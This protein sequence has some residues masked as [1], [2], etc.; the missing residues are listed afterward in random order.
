M[1]RDEVAWTRWV[2]FVD[3]GVAPDEPGLYRFRRPQQAAP[4]Y[5]GETGNG[6]VTLAK[7]LD[8]L[9]SINAPLMPYRYP[10]AAA[11]ALWSLHDAEGDLE[12]SWATV[13]GHHDRRHAAWAAELA[14]HRHQYGSSP[15]ANFGRMPAGYRSS[16]S[17]SC[18]LIHSGG[19]FRGGRSTRRDAQHQP[20]RAPV[21][22]VHD[23]ALLSDRWCGVEWSEWT[24]ELPPERASG[25]VRVRRIAGCNTLLSIAQGGLRQ[26][27]RKAAKVA[28][29]RV[30]SSWLIIDDWPKHQREELFVDLLGAHVLATGQLPGP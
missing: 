5:I 3:R 19:L 9:R 4:D 14:L 21:G 1:S 22:S 6:R 8:A 23:A 11:P 12:V 18:E 25:A 30:E 2:R 20:G 13:P 15:C 17:Y 26:A 27:V 28:E 7:R 10:Y 29:G 24:P 16:S